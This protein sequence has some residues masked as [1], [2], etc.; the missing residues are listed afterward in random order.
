[1]RKRRRDEENGDSRTAGPMGR[2]PSGVPE[3]ARFYGGSSRGEDGGGDVD[4]GDGREYGGGDGRGGRKPLA[5]GGFREPYRGNNRRMGRRGS[6]GGR[7]D[8]GHR[9]YN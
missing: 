1:V 9:P 5:R 8:G 2:G 3:R 6:G 7:G 4:Y